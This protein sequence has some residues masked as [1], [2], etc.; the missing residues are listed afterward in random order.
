MSSRA[1]SAITPETSNC[2]APISLAS[3][4]KRTGSGPVPVAP[5]LDMPDTLKGYKSVAQK[6][7]LGKSSRDAIN[8]PQMEGN[9]NSKSVGA[10]SKGNDHFFMPGHCNEAH[11]VAAAGILPPMQFSLWTQ[12]W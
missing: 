12:V 8:G 10:I 1:I 11:K 5:P 4:P 3:L 9:S 7:A 6:P 2:D